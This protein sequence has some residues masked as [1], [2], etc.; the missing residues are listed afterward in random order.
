M[1]TQITQSFGATEFDVMQ[2][3]QAR[4]IYK[5]GTALGQAEKA[6]SEVQE[7]IDAIKAGDEAE[8]VDGLG[9]VLVCLVNCSVLVDKDLRECFYK[10]YLEI[11][12]RTGQMKADGKFHKSDCK[13][14][15][16]V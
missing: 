7:L 13:C 3:A 2:W 16:C 11:K 14:E 8:I 6:M 15:V 4:G 5:H 12:N 9:D 1:T 10:A